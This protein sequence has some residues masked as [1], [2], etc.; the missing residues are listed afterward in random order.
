MGVTTKVTNC[1]KIPSAG[2]RNRCFARKFKQ[3][4][5][6][7]SRRVGPDGTAGCCANGIGDGFSKE[8]GSDTLVSRLI[9]KGGGAR[10]FAG[11]LEVVLVGDGTDVGFAAKSDRLV[12]DT[13]AGDEPAMKSGGLGPGVEAGAVKDEAGF[14]VKSDGLADGAVDKGLAAAKSDGTGPGVDAGA[15]EDETGFAV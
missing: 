5:R 11:G 3:S 10:L 13:D 6:R 7:F 14:A 2:S 12:P 15:A 9:P 8:L 4:S 1:V